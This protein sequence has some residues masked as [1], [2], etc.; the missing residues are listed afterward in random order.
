[1]DNL[2]GLVQ[3]LSWALIAWLVLTQNLPYAEVVFV[4]NPITTLVVLA[5]AASL[6]VAIARNYPFN[7]PVALQLLPALVDCAG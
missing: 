7:S 4:K 3:S 2:R 5:V 1:M 6:I